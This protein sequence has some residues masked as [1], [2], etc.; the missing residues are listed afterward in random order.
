MKDKFFINIFNEEKRGYGTN[1]LVDDQFY[2]I[3]KYNTLFHKKTRIIRD[4][5][6]GKEEMRELVNFEP[7]FENVQTAFH[8]RVHKRKMCQAVINQR[9]IRKFQKP[10][11]N[12]IFAIVQCEKDKDDQNLFTYNHLYILM[13]FNSFISQALEKIRFIYLR[14]M[15]SYRAMN[16]MESFRE[17]TLEK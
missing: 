16:L 8:G 7:C 3:A 11:W 10:D 5:R 14:K 6:I 9:G 2:V 17:V 4:D 15:T 1:I 13:I 12:S